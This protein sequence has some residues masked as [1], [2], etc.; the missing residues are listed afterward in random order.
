MTAALMLPEEK[1]LGVLF[2]VEPGSLGPDGKLQAQAF[3]DHAEQVMSTLDSAIIK[4]KIVPRF[5]KTLPELEYSIG[6]K[7]LSRSQASKYL[8]LLQHDLDVVEEHLVEQISS[9]IELHQAGT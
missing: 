7:R 6:D 4:W 2:R 5:D 8:V 1:K 9:L 3:C